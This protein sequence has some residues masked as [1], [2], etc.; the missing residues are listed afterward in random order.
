MSIV[1]VPIT[2]AETSECD[3]GLE[4][5][6]RAR[7]AGAD[8]I[9]WRVDRLAD[10]DRGPD[11][12]E[13]LIRESPLPSILTCRSADEGGAFEGTEAERVGLLD[14]MA[15]RG[16]IPAYVDL[17][18]ARWIANS[19][20]QDATAELRHLGAKIILSAHD[21]KGRPEKLDDIF[22][23]IDNTPGCDVT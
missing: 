21:F 20:L 14:Q 15:A 7:G 5:G 18:Y 9:E 8:L 13:T 10:D 1:A 23:S 17:E 12:V 16:A 4:D 22:A 3:R 11:T 2:I 6:V 19:D